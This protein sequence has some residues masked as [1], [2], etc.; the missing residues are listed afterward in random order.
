MGVRMREEKLSFSSVRWFL[1]K[2]NYF[3]TVPDCSV[4]Q[5]WF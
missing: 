4:M 3:R 2:K 5:N 1:L